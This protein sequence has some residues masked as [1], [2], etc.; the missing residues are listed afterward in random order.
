MAKHP[1]TRCPIC[2]HPSAGD[3]ACPVCGWQLFS[4]E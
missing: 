3:P 4:N 2:Q 1:E